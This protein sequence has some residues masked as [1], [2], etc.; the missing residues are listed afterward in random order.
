ML[1]NQETLIEIVEHLLDYQKR[2]E[3]DGEN[4]DDVISCREVVQEHAE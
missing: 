3:S 4:A 1:M 2:L